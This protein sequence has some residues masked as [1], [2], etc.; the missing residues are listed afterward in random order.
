MSPITLAGTVAQDARV[1]RTAQMESLLSFDLALPWLGTDGRAVLARVLK[2]YGQGEAARYAAGAR[3]NR[4]R[5]GV[6][7]VVAAQGCAA[8]GRALLLQDVT[9]I[10]EPDL[11]VPDVTGE[12]K[13]RRED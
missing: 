12:R 8:R 3:A 6:R 11:Y 7:V 9:Q 1:R 2:L 4:L 13:D 10:D 5:R